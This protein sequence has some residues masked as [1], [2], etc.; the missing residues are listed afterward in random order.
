MRV[1]TYYLWVGKVWGECCWST[2]SSI[3][4]CMIFPD[5]EKFGRLGSG[6]AEETSNAMV[7]TTRES[8]HKSV[9]ISHTAVCISVWKDNTGNNCYPYLSCFVA[10]VLCQLIGDILE[11]LQMDPYHRFTVFSDLL[12]V[13]PYIT[14]CVIC[15][16]CMPAGD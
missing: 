8:H 2:C 6:T 16:F 9:Y 15:T 11:L 1:C 4:M 13:Y 5:R 7:S 3:V 10:V 14:Y 12:R